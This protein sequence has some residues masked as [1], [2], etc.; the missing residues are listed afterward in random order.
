MTSRSRILALGT[1]ALAASGLLVLASLPNSAEAAISVIGP[2][3]A[4]TCYDAA[5]NGRDASDYI[6]YCTQALNSVLSTHDRAATYIN[7]GVLKLSLSMTNDA[8][9]DFDAGLALDPA[10]GEGY[11]DRG[12]S[13]IAKRRFADAIESIDKGLSLGA[14]HP[15]IAYYDRAIADEALGD[16]QGAYKDYRQ[17]LELAPDFA[18]ASEELKRFKVVKKNEGS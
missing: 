9:A 14:K 6:I 11:I 1:A 8:L 17:A 4:E 13:L 7:R 12:A 2:G 15:N 18:L 3:P 16:I 5:E 10:L